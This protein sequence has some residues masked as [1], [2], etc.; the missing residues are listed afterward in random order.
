[1]V[2]IVHRQVPE[3]TSQAGGAEHLAL[4]WDP[5]ASVDK[6]QHCQV[7]IV[8]TFVILLGQQDTLV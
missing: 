8:F 2:V 3:Q 1:L 4:D 7:C 5:P 6:A